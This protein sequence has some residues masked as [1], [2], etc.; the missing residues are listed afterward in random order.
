MALGC[1][2]AEVP[3]LLCRH[4]RRVRVDEDEVAVE[5]D[6]AALP[7]P[8]RFAGLDRDAGWLPAAGRSLSFRFQ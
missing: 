1:G 7:L 6:L 4:E 2:H 5:L 3:A 8:V